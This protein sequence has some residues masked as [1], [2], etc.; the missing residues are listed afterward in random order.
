MV[1]NIEAIS[2]NEIKVNYEEIN[3]LHAGVYFYIDG[4]L[5]YGGSY[6]AT[7]HSSKLQYFLMRFLLS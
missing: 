1:K 2:K 7:I 4:E 6:E 3:P 5:I